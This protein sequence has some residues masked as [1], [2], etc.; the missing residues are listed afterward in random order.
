MVEKFPFMVPGA[1]AC[2]EAMVWA[3]Y[4]GAEIGTVP[5]AD[6]AAVEKALD[7]ASRLFKDR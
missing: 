5:R 7:T 3:P 1:K 6:A 2:D 4:D